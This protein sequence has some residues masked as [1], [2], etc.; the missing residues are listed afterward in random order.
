MAWCTNTNIPYDDRNFK[1]IFNFYVFNCPVTIKGNKVS[2]RGRTFE[3]RNITKNS[4]NKL[5]GDMRRFMPNIYFVN[6]EKNNTIDSLID[7][8]KRSK[9]VDNRTKGFE[10]VSCIENTDIR[11]V[12]TIF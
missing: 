10:V 9:S 3:E 2:R 12:K 7:D 5:Y 6:N 1:R 11:R 8:F 4:L